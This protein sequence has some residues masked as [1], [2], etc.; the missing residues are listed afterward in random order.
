[1]DSQTFTILSQ[2][3][4]TEV[5]LCINDVLIEAYRKDSARK[6]ANMVKESMGYSTDQWGGGFSDYAYVVLGGSKEWLLYGTCATCGDL[7]RTYVYNYKTKKFIEL[8]IDS[9]IRSA[10]SHN[11]LCGH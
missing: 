7:V 5:V 2:S 6:V 1:M 8:S 11:Y 9:A 10:R 4:P 3:L